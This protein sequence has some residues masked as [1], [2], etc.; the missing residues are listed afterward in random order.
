MSFAQLS[1]PSGAHLG[2]QHLGLP[3]HNQLISN[4]WVALQLQDQLA[5]LRMLD[6]PYRWGNLPDQC[7]GRPLPRWRRHESLLIPWL[8]VEG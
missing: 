7:Q 4:V 3:S 1:S 8:Q 5:Q 2:V 6:K